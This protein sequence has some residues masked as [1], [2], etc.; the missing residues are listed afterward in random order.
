MRLT[1]LHVDMDAFYAAVEVLDHPQWRGLP[2][3]VGA[4]PD[5]RGVVAT[6]SYEARRYGIH[7]AMPS[8]TAGKLCPR[9]VFVVPRMERYAEMSAKIKAILDGFTPLV[10]PVSLDEAFMDVGGV[11]GRWESAPALAAEVKKRIRSETG[12]T[13][14]IGVAPN[15]FIAKLASDMNKPDGLTIA[16]ATE[17]GIEEFLAPLPVG[18]MWG[19]G[20]VAGAR[21]AREG[22]RTIGQLQR[23]DR[24]ALERLFGKAGAADIAELV[25]GRDNRPVVVDWEEKSISAEHT[26]PLDEPEPERVRQRLIALAEEVGERLRR[27]GKRART[28]Q[29]KLRF[30][31]FTTITRQKSFARAFDGDRDLIACAL[32][33]VEPE[34]NARPIRLVGFG[35]S[36]LADPDA[37]APEQPELFDQQSGGERE[38]RNRRLDQAVDALRRSFGSG[39]LKRGGAGR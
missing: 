16:P 33:L 12:L 8:R 2:V 23:L 22:I 4:P 25:H 20:K 36:N 29:V 17:A 31:D 39:V 5:R 24:S 37:L 11:L 6:C 18:R 1:I 21:L 27:S 9:A 14:S 15:K 3:V 32:A 30:G 28:A 38:G 34:L 10:E 13:A 7:S 26:F 35:V 19:V